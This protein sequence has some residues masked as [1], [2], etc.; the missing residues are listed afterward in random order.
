MTSGSL[1]RTDHQAVPFYRNVKTLTVLAQVAFVLLMGLLFFWLY[2]NMRASFQRTRI[3][4]GFGF[5][6][7]TA[8]FAISEGIP[9]NPSNTMA[10]AFLVGIVNTIR[11]A[12]IGIVLAT[13]LGGLLGIARLSS[14]WLLR[15]IAGTYVAIIRNTPLLVQLIFWYI[16]VILKLPRV[17]DAVGVNG[18][19]FLSNRGLTIAWPRET[20]SFG[21]FQVWLWL[22]VVALI[23]GYFV[24]RRQLRRQDRPGS[25]WPHALLAS[26]LTV[27]LG[28]LIV[29]LSTNIF[30]LRIDQPELAGFNYQGGAGLSPE[31]FGLLMALTIY[32]AAFIAEIVRGGIQAVSKGQREAAQALGLTPGQTLRLVIIPQA[33]R[34]IIPPL[35]NQYLNLTKNSSLGI[36]IGFPDLF[37]VATTIN[38][39]SGAAVQVIVVIMACYLSLSLLTSLIMNIYNARIRLVER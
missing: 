12:A 3:P 28:A 24:R 14:N 39:Q 11:V 13:I 17:R 20:A 25:A 1:S 35:T 37:Y 15:T 22:G 10:R 29:W 34:V 4:L 7:Q 32:T 9:F 21:A 31:F 19:F 2:S 23:A 36:A 30:P 16:A 5:L 26:G 38:N 27:L 33:L 8:G 18:L 6:N